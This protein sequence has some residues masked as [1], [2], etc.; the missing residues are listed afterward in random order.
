MNDVF[1][2]D[3]LSTPA[4]TTAARMPARWGSLL[5]LVAV[6]TQPVATHA[7][8]VSWNVDSSGFWNV[9]ANWNTGTV[10][11]PG[12]DV[13]IDRPSASVTV[14]FSSGSVAVN[15]LT[16]S[17][18]FAITGGML[19]LASTS[20]LADLTMSG[21]TLAGAGNVS[22]SG[23]LTWNGGNMTGSGATNANGGITLAGNTVGLRAARTLNNAATA[24][25]SGAGFFSN[26]N[27][28]TFNNLSGATFAI[29]TPSDFNGG[30]INN[31]G[32]ITKTSGGGNGVTQVAATVNNSNTV[33][34][35][36]GVLQL[37]NGGMQS[38][39]FTIASDATLE[40]GGGTHTF[41]ASASVSGSGNMLFSFG[42]TNFNGGTYDVTGATSCSGGT[43]NFNSAADV[44]DVGTLS[45]SGGTLNRSAAAPSTSTAAT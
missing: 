32:T 6:L 44:D 3:S 4:A 45:I 40:L 11:Q 22:I 34:V 17:E 26:D 39:T 9:A 38:G 2:S 25:W 43:H 21:G 10:P 29:N 35:T 31:A 24:T 1:E 20:T 42:T 28:T 18:S 30:T 8:T 36:S 27:N 7:A 5:L 33:T 19:D 15:S 37:D 23:L 12:D 16:S 13:V 41:T 14:T